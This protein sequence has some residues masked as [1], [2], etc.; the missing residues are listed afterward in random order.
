MTDYK[1][2]YYRMVE[3]ALEASQQIDR[4]NYGLASDLLHKAVSRGTGLC[5][6]EAYTPGEH[7]SLAWLQR[8]PQPGK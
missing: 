2:L 5:E 8:H 7:S 6:E 1:I 3:I 4:R